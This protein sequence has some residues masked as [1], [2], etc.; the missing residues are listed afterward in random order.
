M[1]PITKAAAIALL[2]SNDMWYIH[3][4]A[5][6][7]KFD[8]L[9]ELAESY[10]Y[11]TGHQADDLMELAVELGLPVIHPTSVGTAIPDYSSESNTEY[12]WEPTMGLMRAKLGTYVTAL[13]EVRAT[14]QRPDIQS[15]IDD[16]MECWE[17]ELNY[18]LVRRSDSTPTIL[19]GFKN[20]GLDNKLAY[21]YSSQNG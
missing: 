14:A 4:Y 11:R 17:K 12:T 3:L 2:V 9:H 5:K 16:W 13:K 6:G 19:N 8:Q 18:K 21:T 1:E 10:Y 15:R 7:D 20:T